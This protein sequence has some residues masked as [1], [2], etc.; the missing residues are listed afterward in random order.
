MVPINGKRKVKD[1]EKLIPYGLRLASIQWPE[2]H[3]GE[4]EMNSLRIKTCY[5]SMAKGNIKKNEK[6]FPLH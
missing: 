6:Q 2:E 5:Q 4:S 1:N 3:K